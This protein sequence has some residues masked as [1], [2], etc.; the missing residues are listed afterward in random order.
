MLGVTRMTGEA[1]MGVVADSLSM[2]SKPVSLMSILELR[3]QLQ[4]GHVC[5]EL[6][7]TAVLVAHTITH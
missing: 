2:A 5:L 4:H 6:H 1:R 7:T 3:T